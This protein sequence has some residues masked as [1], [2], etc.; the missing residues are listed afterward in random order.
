MGEES[1]KITAL[2]WGRKGSVVYTGPDRET[3]GT[4]GPELRWEQDAF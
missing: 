2:G 4:R 1:E 3:L